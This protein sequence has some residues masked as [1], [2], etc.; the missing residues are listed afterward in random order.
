MRKADDTP[1]TPVPAR[2]GRRPRN[3]DAYAL[4][5]ADGAIDRAFPVTATR[6]EIAATLA[7][8]GSVLHDDDT[9]TRAADAEPTRRG[10]L[11]GLAMAGLSGAAVPCLT[12]RAASAAPHPDAALLASCADFEAAAR[13]YNGIW[14][15][16]V[17]GTD[18][19]LQGPSYIEDDDERQLAGETFDS[20]MDVMAE[21]ILDTPPVTLDGF[22]A[23]ARCILLS[24]GDVRDAVQGR[25]DFDIL[26]FSLSEWRIVVSLLR[27][28]TGGTVSDATCMEAPGILVVAERGT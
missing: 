24:A 16:R 18:H 14:R 2:L 10:I 1:T 19:A 25:A 23:V 8:L 7:A 27:G 13:S 12:P 28:L 17:W 26:G 22:Q 11:S 21:A 20:R 3:P 15:W 9:V 4:L 5:N 6:A